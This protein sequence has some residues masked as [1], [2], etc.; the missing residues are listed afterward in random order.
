MRR[1]F[2]QEYYLE[3]CDTIRSLKSEQLC[4]LTDF[5]GDLILKIKAWLEKH[6]VCDPTEDIRAH[7]RELLDRE[8]TTLEKLAAIFQ[9]VWATD[10]VFGT[11]ESYFN[12]TVTALASYQN[13][14]R[15]L[16]GI[17]AEAS[18]AVQSGGKLQDCLSEK[19]IRMEM[20]PLDASL[21]ADLSP[22]VFALSTFMV[23]ND[24]YFK[25]A[26]VEFFEIGHPEYAELMAQVL[27]DPD[28][29]DQERKDIRYLIY[30]AP[31]P[32]RS[33]YL[34]H[35]D[36]FVV[37]VDGDVDGAYYSGW[38]RE[39]FIRD[40]DK[41]FADDPMAPYTTFFH[42]SGH[43]I[44]D[45]ENENGYMLT[46]HFTYEGQSLHD[47]V[48][49]DVRNYVE[50]YIRNDPY[51][52]SLTEEQRQTVLWGLNLTDNAEFAYGGGTEL[53]DPVLEAAR[54]AVINHMKTDL[55]GYENGA[56][57]DVYGGVTNN[58]IYGNWGHWTDTYWYNG[59]SATGSQEIELW[60]EFFGAKMTGDEAT[61]AS[62]RAHFPRAYDAMEAMA[63]EM[64]SN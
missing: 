39:I 10:N 42:E 60:A 29:T 9:E 40:T 4:F 18:V 27:S 62:I 8:N 32:Y 16:S 45:F 38:L 12:G 2:T 61:L 37:H 24:P 50:D 34:E 30:S 43:A 53:S 17:A 51:L 52:S 21:N 56:A 49:G 11:G 44:D 31:E 57:S 20:D 59:N 13:Y 5:F 6:G 28:L 35:V 48:T 3:L 41:Y 7:H 55:A 64:A 25:T 19:T 22:I 33:I 1:D 63:L 14:V 23:N 26:Y 46:T 58:A 36:S 54:Q 47:L 15:T